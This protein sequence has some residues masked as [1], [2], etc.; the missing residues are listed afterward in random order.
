M[1]EQEEDPGQGREFLREVALSAPSFPACQLTMEPTAKREKFLFTQDNIF[2]FHSVL[3][4]KNMTFFSQRKRE[5]SCPNCM[6]GGGGDLKGKSQALI[7]NVS[8]IPKIYVILQTKKLNVLQM[9][10]EDLITGCMTY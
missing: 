6:Q 4:N 9:D 10:L 8:G 1:R 3:N 5:R 2:Y 7:V